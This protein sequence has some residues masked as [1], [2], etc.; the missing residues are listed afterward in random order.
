[1]VY[2]NIDIIKELTRVK[3]QTRWMR[4]KKK[5]ACLCCCR[6]TKKEVNSFFGALYDDKDQIPF[7]CGA[8]LTN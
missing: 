5:N 8:H 7:S 2:L 6:L 1:M 4:S 3:Q